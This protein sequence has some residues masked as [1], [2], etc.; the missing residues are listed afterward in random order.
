[1][2]RNDVEL[3]ALACEIADLDGLDYNEALERARYELEGV[4]QYARSWNQRAVTPS[5]HYLD[6]LVLLEHGGR[7]TPEQ[8]QAL[9]TDDPVVRY[10][11]QYAIER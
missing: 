9:L 2:E 3:H 6:A 4:Q 10:V 11:R 1:M 5:T 8:I 7:L